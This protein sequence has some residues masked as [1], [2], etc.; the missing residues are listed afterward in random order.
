MPRSV[1]LVIVFALA[2][3][4]FWWLLRDVEPARSGPTPLEF[5]SPIA[6]SEPP[7]DDPWT[8]PDW[9]LPHFE[10]A[11]EAVEAV[12]EARFVARP[13][14]RIGRAIELADLYRLSALEYARR[15]ELPEPPALG[16]NESMFAE[17]AR[18]Q[19]GRY[20][21]E[22]HAITVSKDAIPRFRRDGLRESLTGG[23]GV[24]LILVHELTHAWQQEQVPDLWVKRVFDPS[25]E[26][27]ECASAIG[28]GH[29]QHVTRLVA[30]H[31]GMGRF[32]D[33]FRAFFEGVDDGQHEQLWREY[34]AG[35]DFIDAVQRARGR[36]G[37]MQA[38][39][40]P[41]RQ[42]AELLDP[43]RWLSRT[44]PTETGE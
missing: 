38:L 25:K 40:D 24:R 18:Y 26:A 21:R 23:D 37:V 31:W 9:L 22:A 2:G 19:L 16:G 34:V 35:Q 1:L 11:C 3:A 41:P 44:R 10:K 29:A 5:P 15:E 43:A 12:C 36:A 14:L 4:A 39:R 30:K 8:D 32:F 20:F 13:T 33:D 27:A 6:T 42:R 28:E 7:T 17:F